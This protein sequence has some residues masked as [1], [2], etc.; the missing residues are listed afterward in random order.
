MG[1]NKREIPSWA[2][3]LIKMFLTAIVLYVSFYLGIIFLLAMGMYGIHAYI[4]IAGMF[5]LPALILPQIWTKK[6]KKALIGGLIFTMLYAVVF[7][8]NF[9]M[10]KYTIGSTPVNST[11]ISIYEG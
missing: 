6:R 8:I 3:L 4:A 10:V 7:G 9:G 5:V 1:E 11:S 2:K